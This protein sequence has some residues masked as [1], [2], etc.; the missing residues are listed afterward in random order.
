MF[1]E[2][3][4][5][6]NWL[7]ILVAAI[8]YFALGAIWYGL[9]FSKQWIKLTGLNM[10][11]PNAK[12]GVITIMFTSFLMMLVQTIGIALLQHH[13]MTSSLLAGFKMGAFVGVFFCTTSIAINYLYTKK[14]LMLYVID[15]GYQTLGCGVAAAILA[16]WM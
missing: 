5:Q 10:D 3:L 12:K 6:L 14:A 1:T 13:F 4:S 16:A 2:M 7:H 15:C 9:L 8:A 11:D